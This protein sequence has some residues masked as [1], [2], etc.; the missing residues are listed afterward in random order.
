MTEDKLAA[1]REKRDFTNTP[2]P[3]GDADLVSEEPVFVVQKHQARS[4]HYDVR[5]EVEGVLKSWAVPKG[6]S[7]ITRNRRL[8]IPT[9]DHPLEYVNFESNIPEKEYGAGAVML[10]DRGT[11]EN[12]STDKAGNPVSMAEAVAQGHL[13][14]M[15]HG[16]KLRGGFAL[17]HTGSRRGREQWIMI[18]M[19]DETANPDTD[20]VDEQNRS[21]LTGRTLEEIKGE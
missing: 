11:Y 18:K 6:P 8:A 12:I 9:E 7:M 20:P 3:A 4:L 17:H 14:V 1:Y 15:L 5:L 13:S 21:V 16:E 19:S 2:E 10:W